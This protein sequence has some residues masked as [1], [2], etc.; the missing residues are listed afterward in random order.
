[1]PPFEHTALAAAV[2]AAG[3]TSDLRRLARPLRS[4]EPVVA[5]SDRILRAAGH[6]LCYRS[7]AGAVPCDALHDELIFGGP[8]LLKLTAL[9]ARRRGFRRRGGLGAAG[10]FHRGSERRLRVGAAVL[11]REDGLDG[12]PKLQLI[13]AQHGEVIERRELVRQRLK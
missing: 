9:P 3:D 10:G 7:P 12:R 5:V 1:M 13:D 8:P 2:A 11:L 4:L 6:V